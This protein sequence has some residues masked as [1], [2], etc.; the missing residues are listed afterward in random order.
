MNEKSDLV[1]TERSV[2]SFMCFSESAGRLT[3]N[4][5]RW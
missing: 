3:G 4:Y 5:R 1:H 2:R